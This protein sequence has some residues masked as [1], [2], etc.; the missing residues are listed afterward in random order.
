MYD[1]LQRLWDEA[2]MVFF[3]VL[4]RYLLGVSEKKQT[5]KAVYVLVGIQ[6]WYLL[7]LKQEALC[8][9]SF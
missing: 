2:V 5:L 6:S 9:F 7:H 8:D 3:M 1:A 4:Y